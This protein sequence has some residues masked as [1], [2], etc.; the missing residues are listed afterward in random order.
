M[1]QAAD[2]EE[3]TAR[4]AMLEEAKR[5]KEEEATAWQNKVS[6]CVCSSSRQI[7][8]QNIFRI[9]HSQIL[10][11]LQA[12]EV[13]N[14][15]VKTK[16][17]LHMV[18]TVP[19]PPPPPPSYNHL[20]DY[21]DNEENSSNHSAEL[22]TMGFSDHSLEEERLTEVE[23]NER[24]QKQLKVRAKSRFFK[25]SYLDAAYKAKRGCRTIGTE[26]LS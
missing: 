17:E 20:E 14:D 9:V 7:K 19:P 23:K 18:M 13:Q 24:V 21:S 12:Q 15:L 4:I 10:L 8:V 5:R 22:Q 26:P 16:E 11:R 2:L 6:C 1:H 3:Y 25:V